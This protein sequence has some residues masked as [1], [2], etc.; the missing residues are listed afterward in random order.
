[1]HDYL[2]PTK[3]DFDRNIFILHD[4]TNNLSTNNSPEMIADKIV[5]TAQSLKTEDNNF[6]L[7]AIIPR[8][9]KL[10]TKNTSNIT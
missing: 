9:N 10:N 7:S 4:G 2:K 5:E 1:M 6:I 8:V 3:R